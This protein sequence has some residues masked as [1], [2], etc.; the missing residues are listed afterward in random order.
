MENQ[1]CLFYKND[2]LQFGWIREVRKNKPVVVPVQ[3]KEF[4]CAGSRLEYIWPA[5]LFQETNEAL[6]YLSKK[7]AETEAASREIDL[8]VIHELCD[9]GVAYSLDEMADSFLDDPEDGWSRVAL[10]LAIKNDRQLF[11]QKKHQ[12]FARSDEEIQ[13]L[14]EEA[15]RKQE[16]ERRRQLE[17]QWAE[18]LESGNCPEIAEKDRDHWQLFQQRV[19]NDLKFLDRSQEKEY[20]RSL[21]HCQGEETV[22][23]ERKLLG[24][25]AAAGCDFSWGRLLL[26][27]VDLPASYTEEEISAVATLTDRAARDGFFDLVTED[28]SAA[29]TFTVDHADTR[30]Y[31]DAVSLISDG[32]EWL[33]RVHIAD[34]ASFIEPDSTLFHACEMRMSSLYTV[35]ETFPML[36]RDLSEDLFSLREGKDRTVMTFEARIDENRDLIDARIYRSVINVNRNLSYET[37]DA[38]IDAADPFWTTV[39][40]FCRKQK[41]KRM[42]NGAL[43]LSRTEIK[44]DISDPEHIRIREVRENTPASLL[45]EELAVFV[46]HQAAAFC[47]DRDLQCLYR[48]QPPY[49][50][51]QDLTPGVLP[52]LQDIQIQPA[53]VGT[54]PEGH[55]ALGLDCYLQVT[56]PIRRFLDLINQGILFAALSDRERL[57]SPDELLDWARRGEEA[58]REYAAIEKRLLD[59]WKI[60]YLEQHQTDVFDAHLFR[61]LRSGKTLVTITDL[62]L[63][64]ECV[65]DTDPPGD[66]FQICLDQVVARYDRVIAR[67]HTEP[68]TA[69]TLEG[70]ADAADSL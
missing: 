25:L 37:V 55:A 33:L 9:K 10:L 15:A 17:K 50:V 65:I 34:V 2:R 35:K 44:L 45:I 11:Q 28:E 62:Q 68:G 66:A 46:N 6:T 26:S 56:S 52:T 60:R 41:E 12:F 64:V 8:D 51:H 38:A 67:I 24:V 42:E 13:K 49:T 63:I 61:R 27:R 5:Q 1:Y 23:V 4:S 20:F 31:D 69:D 30:D 54:F 43:A 70:N 21:F 19:F 59:H 22:V 58:Q 48:N 29:L 14:Q 57:Y 40:E 3:G 16:T 7:A 32:S 39:W 53:R 36:H 18:Q 47:K